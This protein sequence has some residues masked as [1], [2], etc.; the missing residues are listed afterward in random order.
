MS[1]HSA[2]TLV[3]GPCSTLLK[4]VEDEIN[5][6]VGPG[7]ALYQAGKDFYAFS[8]RRGTWGVLHLE[9]QEEPTA[10]A[11]PADIEVMQGNRLYVFSLKQGEWSRGVAVY[12]QPSRPTRVAK[13]RHQLRSRRAEHT[14][15]TGFRWGGSRIG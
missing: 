1:P 6:V 2:L 3:S 15:A 10:T 8:A 9:G 7:S 4:P 13:S 12:Q 14:T 11:S 5:P